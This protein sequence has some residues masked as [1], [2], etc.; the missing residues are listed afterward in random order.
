M[1]RVPVC[2]V[3]LV[4]LGGTDRLQAQTFVGADIGGS[5]AVIFDSDE[6]SIASSHGAVS[7]G[8]AVSGYGSDRYTGFA[9]DVLLNSESSTGVLGQI[10]FGLG[11]PRVTSGGAGA[12]FLGVRSG[13]TDVVHWRERDVSVY[14]GVF[15]VRNDLVT[16]P[17]LVPVGYRYASRKGMGV[18]LQVAPGF[19]YVREQEPEVV[20][21]EVGS[22]LPV[23]EARFT[24]TFGG[25][26]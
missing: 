16:I 17:V 18:A 4:M 19:L 22:F 15:E 11:R 21:A 1:K 3:L 7:L 25:M 26:L 5:V 6:S 13:V 2:F 24:V 23:V 12:L 9:L 10:E 8:F 14:G 20:E